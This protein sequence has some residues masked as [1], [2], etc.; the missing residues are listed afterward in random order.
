MNMQ[1]IILHESPKIMTGSLMILAVL[2]VIGG[3][4][5]VPHVLE[6]PIIFMNSLLL[7]WEV[8]LNLPKPM[9]GFSILTQAWASG[10]RQEDI[11]RL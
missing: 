2:S 11:R 5:G 8:G 4:I 1:P 10:E 9:R 3:Y 7:Y 6:E